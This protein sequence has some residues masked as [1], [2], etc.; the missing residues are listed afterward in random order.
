MGFDK[1]EKKAIMLFEDHIEAFSELLGPYRKRK[2]ERGISYYF[3]N[4]SQYSWTKISCMSNKK[5]LSNT[6]FID[7]TFVMDDLD[8]GADFKAKLVFTGAI[9]MTGVKLKAGGGDQ[10]VVEALNANRP[11]MEELL[12]C[13][14]E[15]DFYS[16]TF[17]YNAHIR[18]MKVVI[19]PYNG[20]YLW[21]KFP[22]VFYPMRFSGEEIYHLCQLLNL[23]GKTFR[24][25]EMNHE[26]T[27]DSKM[28]KKMEARS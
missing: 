6:Y 28:Q 15:V 27:A 20:G 25:E 1:G 22:P 4:Y 18:Q 17:E 3:E 26:K 9:K 13:S 5:L 10:R 11:F 7:F 14:K 21:I 8:L 16:M 2:G 23:L 19:T 12:K 24:D